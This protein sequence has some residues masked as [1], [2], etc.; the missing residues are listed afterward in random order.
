MQYVRVQPDT[1]QHTTCYPCF[2]AISYRIA[3]CGA[4]IGGHFAIA[5]IARTDFL[6]GA[7]TT[8]VKRHIVAE[9]IDRIVAVAAHIATPRGTLAKP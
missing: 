3:L 4:N 5:T 6:V 2:G 9:S 1:A 8:A 7:G